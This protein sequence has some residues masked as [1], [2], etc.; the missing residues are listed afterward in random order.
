MGSRK[1]CDQCY[2]QGAIPGRRGRRGKWVHSMGHAQFRE[3][4]LCTMTRANVQETRE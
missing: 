4:Q 1:E 3:Y 2:D